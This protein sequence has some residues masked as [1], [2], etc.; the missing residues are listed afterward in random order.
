[1]PFNGRWRL[2]LK[3]AATQ[4]R[5]SFR[6]A[7]AAILAILSFTLYGC[8]SD[9]PSI[10]TRQLKISAAL[11]ANADSPV[12]VDLVF[13][14]DAD[15]LAAV[16]ALPAAQWFKDKSQI[17]LA[18]PTGFKVKSFELAPQRNV[19]YEVD[20]EEDEAV[21]I[22]VFAG[23]AAPG[24]HRARVDRIK[25]PVIRLGRTAFSVEPGQ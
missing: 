9:L 24:T 12:A 10:D 23:Y 25:Q 5:S 13:A 20:G 2:P 4:G 22:F 19:Q 8:G 21:G 18:Q 16:A 7:T 17:T 3:M 6:A 1:M 15:A 11:D 14:M